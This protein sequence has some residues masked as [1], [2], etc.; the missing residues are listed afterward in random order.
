ME[1]QKT[2]EKKQRNPTSTINDAVLQPEIDNLQPDIDDSKLLRIMERIQEQ[3]RM[4]A[5]VDMRVTYRQFIKGCYAAAGEEIPD[6][7]IDAAIDY[8]SSKQLSSSYASK[9]IRKIGVPTAIAAGLLSIISATA[10]FVSPYKSAPQIHINQTVQDVNEI[11]EA[12]QN[13]GRRVIFDEVPSY[14]P[15]LVYIFKK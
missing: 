3:R 11:K 9:I 4:G 5:P 8:V 15:P 6:E 7:Q 10:Y 2:I 1:Q 14:A 13:G 12:P